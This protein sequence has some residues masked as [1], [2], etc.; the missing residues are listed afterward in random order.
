MSVQESLDHGMQSLVFFLNHTHLLHLYRLFLAEFTFVSN[1]HS[2][3]T[4]LIIFLCF[5]YPPKHLK[6]ASYC[7]LHTSVKEGTQ[8][9]CTFLDD[10][11]ALCKG[12]WQ[13]FS[14]KRNW[15]VWHGKGIYWKMSGSLQETRNLLAP[16][17]Q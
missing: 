9:R 14:G 4:F 13:V 17:L 6:L 10:R 15:L 11:Y 3:L 1:S 7:N 5:R 2:E 16:P 12:T 8:D